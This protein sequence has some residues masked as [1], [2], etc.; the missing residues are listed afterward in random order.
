VQAGIQ[1]ILAFPEKNLMP[2]FADMTYLKSAA[3][4][5]INSPAFYAETLRK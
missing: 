5:N 3:E 4:R 1:A 2:A